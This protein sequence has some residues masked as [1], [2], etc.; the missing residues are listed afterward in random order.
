M[1]HIHKVYKLPEVHIESNVDSDEEVGIESLSSARATVIAICF[2]SVLL[3]A[4]SL[5]LYDVHANREREIA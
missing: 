4:R 1:I 2:C 5:T 3:L